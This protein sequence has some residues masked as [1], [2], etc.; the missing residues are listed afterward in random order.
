MSR[1]LL[2]CLV[3]LWILPGSALAQN[4]TH[5]MVSSTYGLSLGVFFPSRTIDLGAGANVQGP[6]QDVDFRDSFGI[7]R[8]DR[9]FEADF[10]WRFGEKWS[11]AGQYYSASDQ[12]TKS[13]EEDVTWNDVEFGADTFIRAETGLKLMRVFFGRSIGNDDRM[14]AGIGVGFHWLDLRASV[15]GE[16]LVGDGLEF[17]R[18]VVGAKAPLPNIG[19]WY[20]RSLSPRWAFQARADWFSAD[21]GE[22]DGRLLNLSVGAEYLLFRN[23]SLGVAYNDFELDVSVESSNWDGTAEVGYEGP[24]VYLSFYW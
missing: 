11:L 19:A 16:I 10:I 23:A 20:R 5:P 6:Q 8:S 7:A 2:T 17:R 15:E 13:L 21:I 9:L 4:D 22:Y 14:D 24:Y 18:E 3:F 12:A 1:R